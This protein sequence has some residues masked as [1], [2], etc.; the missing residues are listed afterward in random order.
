MAPSGTEQVCCL[1]S[2]KSGD[3]RPSW[4]FRALPGLSPGRGTW[5][6]GVRTTAPTLED[7]RLPEQAVGDVGG[8]VR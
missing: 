4:G 8:C 7:L 3:E 1:L 5:E 6:P 2:L